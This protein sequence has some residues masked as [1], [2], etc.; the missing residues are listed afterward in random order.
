MYLWEEGI[1]EC[2]KAN[3]DCKGEGRHLRKRGNAHVMGHEG[4]RHREKALQAK[5]KW[6][7]DGT[8]VRPGVTG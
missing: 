6:W 7:L 3:G 5:G 1:T 4:V 2:A 8:Q